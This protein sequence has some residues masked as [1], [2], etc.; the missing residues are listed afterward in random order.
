MVTS[1]V[2]TTS[3]ASCAHST[4]KRKC[5]TGGDDEILVDDNMLLFAVAAN[6]CTSDENFLT[7]RQPLQREGNDD[8]TPYRPS[9][10][11]SCAAVLSVVRWR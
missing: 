7:T 9:C 4:P 1:S 6:V 10:H 2:M 8:E 11:V 3:S 5:H